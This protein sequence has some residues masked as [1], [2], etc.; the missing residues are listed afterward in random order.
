MEEADKW[1]SMR[2]LDCAN[3]E[4]DSI[5]IEEGQERPFADFFAEKKREIPFC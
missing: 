4:A 3:W 5:D 2:A 1:A